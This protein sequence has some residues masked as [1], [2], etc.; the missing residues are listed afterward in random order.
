MTCSLSMIRGFYSASSAHHLLSPLPAFS[1]VGS[2]SSPPDRTAHTLPP[3]PE[4]PTSHLYSAGSL[5][6]P[7]MMNP[8]NPGPT[9]Q[10]HLHPKATYIPKP[11][12]S[13]V[14]KL[15][16]TK[17]WPSSPWVKKKI[18]IKRNSGRSFY[19]NI[20]NASLWVAI[21][22]SNYVLIFLSPFDTAWQKQPSTES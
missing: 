17:N 15:Q 1:E 3:Q 9:S 12:L 19:L 4:L 5:A 13:S 14:M 10:S 6:S 8:E 11:P 2:L 7:V 18:I 20:I 22:F 16:S 21:L